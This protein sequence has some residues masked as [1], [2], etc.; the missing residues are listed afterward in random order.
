MPRD[1]ADEE[2]GGS[3]YPDWV[4]LPRSCQHLPSEVGSEHERL[5]LQGGAQQA[6]RAERDLDAAPGG[7]GPTAKALA[8]L[9]A[10]AD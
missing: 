2:V 9:R 10:A 3:G 8:R 1:E 5:Q 7:S 6:Q 4:V